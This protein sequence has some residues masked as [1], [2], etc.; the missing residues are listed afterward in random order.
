ML[1]MWDTQEKRIMIVC[2]WIEELDKRLEIVRDL[3]LRK[4]MTIAKDKLK[5]EYDQKVRLLELQ[6]GQMVLMRI[7]GLTGK[8]DDSW[9]GLDQSQIERCEL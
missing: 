1:H 8:L 2:A 5:K 6:I 4:K 7:P 3:P 9:D